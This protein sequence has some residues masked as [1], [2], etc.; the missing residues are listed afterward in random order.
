[1]ARPGDCHAGNP[2]HYDT[3]LKRYPID[4]RRTVLAGFSQGGRTAI[5][6][7][8][9]GILPARG[10]LGIACALPDEEIRSLLRD[11]EPKHHGYLIVG[12][13]DYVYEQTLGMADL[14]RSYLTPV[15]VETIEGLAHEIPEDFD[16]RLPRIL[17]FLLS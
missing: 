8:L 7:T 9:S 2:E 10:F 6:L 13:K 16:L 5:W 11:R 3:I 15:E 14:L 4:A 1:M 12:T 17:D